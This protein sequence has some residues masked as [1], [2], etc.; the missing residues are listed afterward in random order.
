MIISSSIELLIQ[1]TI[2][3]PQEVIVVTL[4][5]ASATTAVAVAIINNSTL[6]L[7]IFF[8]DLLQP[9]LTAV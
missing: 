3:E 7:S 6:F 8:V 5:L 4:I 2:E 1:V 9:E